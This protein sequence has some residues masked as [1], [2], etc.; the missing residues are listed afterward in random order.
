MPKSHLLRERK[1][2]NL[3]R[4]PLPNVSPWG[5]PGLVVGLPSRPFFYM[6]AV[7]NGRFVAQISP[8]AF[9][10]SKWAFQIGLFF[11]WPVSKTVVPWPK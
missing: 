11:I 3:G 2:L 7:E 5:L 8:R 9:W 4:A 1:T 6:A 10:A